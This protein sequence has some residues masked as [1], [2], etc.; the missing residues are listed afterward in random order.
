[1]ALEDM[2]ER[3]IEAG[4]THFELHDFL[5]ERD[6][7]RVAFHWDLYRG[8]PVRWV[9]ITL[10]WDIEVEWLGFG[11]DPRK[12]LSRLP[13]RVTYWWTWRVG[14]LTGG[15]RHGYQMSERPTLEAGLRAALGN[16]LCES[17]GEECPHG[18]CEYHGD[19][20]D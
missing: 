19:C 15:E 10:P 5:E 3:C 12:R 8:E 16:F 6:G 9:N 13:F 20:G 11:P 7:Q 4:V 2:I 1:M 18:I 14:L 17:E